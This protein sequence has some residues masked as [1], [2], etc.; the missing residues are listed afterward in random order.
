MIYSTFDIYKKLNQDA[1]FAELVRN[2]LVQFFHRYLKS[3]ESTQPAASIDQ[4]TV[5]G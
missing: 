3:R 5:P 2:A 4:R 1:T